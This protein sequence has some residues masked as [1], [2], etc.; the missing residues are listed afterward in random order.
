MER[1]KFIK[2]ILPLAAAVAA[3]FELHASARQAKEAK[4]NSLARLFSDPQS[5]AGLGKAF[6]ASFGESFD[7]ERVM[8]EWLQDDLFKQLMGAPTAPGSRRDLST[9]LIADF[10]EGVT[11]SVDGWVLSQTEARL[12][13]LIYL[14]SV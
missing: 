9:R 7:R 8:R 11:V 4:S 10:N 6:V 3:P 12:C 13:G 1:R 14:Q 2:L 5:A